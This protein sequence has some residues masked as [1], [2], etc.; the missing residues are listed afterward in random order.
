VSASTRKSEAF[1]VGPN[2]VPNADGGGELPRLE[3]SPRA[4]PKAGTPSW[5]AQDGG[6]TRECLATG[7]R[8]MNATTDKEALAQLLVEAA[9]DGSLE[10][11]RGLHYLLRELRTLGPGV[12][13]EVAAA[14]VPDL[15]KLL[16]RGTPLQ[17]R[18]SA[19]ALRELGPAARDAIPALIEALHAPDDCLD[20]MALQALLAQD[21]APEIAVPALARRLRVSVRKCERSELIN[22]LGRFGPRAEPAIPELLELLKYRRWRFCFE[23]ADALLAIGP[24]G[25]RAL[26]D[27]A[28][29]AT[30]PAVRQNAAAALRVLEQG[31]RGHRHPDRIRVKVEPSWLAWRDRTVPRLAEVARGDGPAFAGVLADALEEAGCDD[32]C[33]LAHLRLPMDHAP[34]CF[35]VR[36]ILAAARPTS[37]AAVFRAAKLGRWYDGLTAYE[38]QEADEA[39][40]DYANML[41]ETTFGRLTADQLRRVAR[42]VRGAFERR[43]P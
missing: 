1:S 16:R 35:A 10:S 20:D 32:A 39:A 14:A 43:R 41:Y 7:T 37:H 28:R 36:T 11:H 17:R 33:L 23:A 3:Q 24:V 18:M 19:V 5:T 21:P 38:Q 40:D 22:A 42:H 31:R 30:S 2:D 25:V 6:L 8:C 26:S 27:A 13:P 29:S 12:K 4:E 15:A 34:D 9:S